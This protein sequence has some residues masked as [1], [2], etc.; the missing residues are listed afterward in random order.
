MDFPKEQIEELKQ[1]YGEVGFCEEGGY[2][3]FFIPN[4]PLPDGCAPEKV[5]VLL[6]PMTRDSYPSRLF[7][8]EKIKTKTERNWNANGTHILERN[9]YAF[10]WKV[11]QPN[12]RLIQII[13][14]HLRGLR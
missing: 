8:A 2:N 1:I 5:D 7:F 4:L 10:S 12:L 14:A 13:R 3:Y 6:C 9:W 11:N